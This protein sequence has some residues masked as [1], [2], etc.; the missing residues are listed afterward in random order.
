[1][2]FFISIRSEL[3]IWLCVSSS[4]FGKGK[5]LFYIYKTVCWNF[6]RRN[7]ENPDEIG[8]FVDYIFF[9]AL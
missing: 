8:V 7:G 6:G 4:H 1:M 2:D 3:F 5:R 9:V